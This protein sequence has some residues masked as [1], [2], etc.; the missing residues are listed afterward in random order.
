MA[1]VVVQLFFILLIRFWPQFEYEPEI[2]FLDAPREQVLIDEIQITQQR[3]SPPPPP[4]PQ[5]PQ[6]VPSDEIIEIELDI[7]L[8]LDVPEMPDL[9]PGQGTAF[10]GEEATI[11]SNPQIPPTVV[12]IV[13]AS[14]PAGVPAELR[15]NIEMIVNFLVDENGT[16]EEASIV[17]IRKYSNGD[18]Y[19]VLPFIEHGLMDA[20]LRAALQWRFR[21]AR[22]DGENVRS[23]TRQR[24]NY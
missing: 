13:E 21:P 2:L 8:D 9:E 3:S 11:V 15:G 17:E 5:V 18:D 14:T 23:Y 4:R 6:P 19:E 22:Q 24:F 20:V 7:D 1:V 16:V 10:E 12:R